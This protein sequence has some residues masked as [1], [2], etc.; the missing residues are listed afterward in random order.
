MKLLILNYEYPPLGGGAGAISKC[1]AEGFAKLKHEVTVLSTWFTDLDEDSVQ[2]GVRVIRLKSKRKFIYCS[3]PREMYSWIIYAKKFLNTHLKSETYDLIFANFSMPGGEVAYSMKIKF[4]IPYTVISHGHDIPWFAPQQMFW[5]HL[6][7]Y[8]WIRTIIINSE[9]NFVQS[10]E[11]KENIDRFTGPSFSKKNMII[12]NGWD[13]SVFN[14]DY[15]KRSKEFVILFPGRLVKQ[16]DPFTF[17]KALNILKTN[18]YPFKVHVLGDGPLRKSM[19]Q[20]VNRHGLNEWVEF[21]GWVTRD[22][23]I[24][25]YQ[26]GSL[27]VLPSITEGMSMVVLESLACGQYLITT[28]VS[29]NEVLIKHGINGDFVAKRDP[30]ML[31]SL[32][33]KFY[34][35]KFSEN[36]LIS[37]NDL[38]KYHELYEWDG[39]VKQYET[40]FLKIINN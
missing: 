18:N 38:R 21:K 29:N 12:Y 6:F 34:N 19:E 10:H 39:I 27:T 4:G 35:D 16:K 11:M 15:S 8:H 1:I 22:K 13:S 17:L 33:A 30:E 20:F 23:M 40:E 24:E 5:Y 9:K 32:I 2:N 7:T 28:R 26:S 37:E 31:A 36:Y 14:P 3:N 25:E